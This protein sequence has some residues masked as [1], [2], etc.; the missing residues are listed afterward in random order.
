MYFWLHQVC[1]AA[2]A[3]G[4]KIYGC[5]LGKERFKG[6]DG[7]DLKTYL[8]K[9]KIYGDDLVYFGGCYL[10]FNTLQ[11]LRVRVTD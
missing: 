8:L 7:P 9:E 2:A 10:V 4:S 11:P 6:P 5:F 1:L 3:F